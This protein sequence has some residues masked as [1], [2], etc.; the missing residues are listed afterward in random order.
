[1]LRRNLE[2][3]QSDGP[4]LPEDHRDEDGDQLEDLVERVE[5]EGTEVVVEVDQV[6]TGVVEVE[7][8][9]PA[10]DLLHTEITE[11]TNGCD[12]PISGSVDLISA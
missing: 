2:I 3:N 6:L 11:N 5:H 12:G 9:D 4:P 7:D 1:M 10:G 8:L